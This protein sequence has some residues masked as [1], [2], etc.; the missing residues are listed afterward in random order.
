MTEVDCGGVFESGGARVIRLTGLAVFECWIAVYSLKYVYRFGDC[1][2][3]GL[4]KG[5]LIGSVLRRQSCRDGRVRAL[6][7]GVDE[8]DYC[9]RLLRVPRRSGYWSM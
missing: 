1:K 2:V 7:I 6:R 5:S 3:F 4:K 8:T 9:F